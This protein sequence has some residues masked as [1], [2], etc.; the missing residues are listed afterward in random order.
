MP[1]FQYREESLA[2][3]LK[4]GLGPLAVLLAMAVAAFG[5]AY[6]SFVRTD[7]R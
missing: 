4:A 7:P 6:L 2:A 1:R 5:A 3:R